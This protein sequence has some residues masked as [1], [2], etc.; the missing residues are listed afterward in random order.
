[1]TTKSLPIGSGLFIPDSILKEAGIDNCVVEL[2]ISENQ[3]R[4]SSL[5]TH[6]RKKPKK[7]TDDSRFL[8][9]IGMIQTPGVNGRDHDKYLYERD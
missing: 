4:I 2:E 5:G 3:I 1:M 6:D 9:L 8:K 7:V